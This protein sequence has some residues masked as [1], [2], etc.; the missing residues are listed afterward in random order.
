M[1]LKKNAYNCTE[2]EN[3]LPGNKMY[4]ERKNS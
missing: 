1:N 4:D 2:K 3:R